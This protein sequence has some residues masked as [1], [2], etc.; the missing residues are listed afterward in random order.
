M[1]REGQFLKTLFERYIEIRKELG[2][3][4]SNINTH[5][6]YGSRNSVMTASNKPLDEE[7]FEHLLRYFKFFIRPRMFLFSIGFTNEQ[8]EEVSKS[9][10]K[11][12]N[13]LCFN[14]KTSKTFKKLKQNEVFRKIY[15]ENRLK[16]SESFG[17]Y[18]NSFNINFVEDGIFFVDIGYHGTMQDMI[19]KYFDEKIAIDKKFKIE[20]NVNTILFSN[21]QLEHLIFSNL[22]GA[23]S[24][25]KLS[26][27][28]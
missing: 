3:E 4:V 26:I 1:S 20:V 2:L 22:S 18:M 9:F 28:F 19:F 11:A 7:T 12:I 25:K 15:E 21:V 5:Y 23:I 16:Q 8:L 13:K 14:F 10:G 24:T 6:F 27:Y 17:K